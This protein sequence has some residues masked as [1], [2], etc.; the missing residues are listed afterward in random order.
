VSV[1]AVIPVWNGRELLM[2]LLDT[3]EAQTVKFAEV[4]ILDNGSTDGGPE[5]AANRGA[6]VVRLGRNQGFAAAVNRGVAEAQTAKVAILNTDVELGPEWLDRLLLS[7]A[8]F[9]TGRIVSAADPSVIDGT[10]DLLCRGG[11]PWRAG[12]GKR[13]W[14]PGGPIEIAPFTAVL[15]DRDA[16]LEVGMLDEQF[17]S[18]LEDV[19]F[20]LRCADLGIRGEFIPEAVCRHHGSATLGRWNADSV[21]RMSRNQVFLIAKH[22]P[23]R[24]IL[25]AGWAILVAQLLWGLVAARHGAGWGW[26][27]GKIEGI[28]RF[29]EVR[30]EPIEDLGDLLSRQEAAIQELQERLGMDCYWRTYFFWGGAK[31]HS[32]TRGVAT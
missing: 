19:D 25:E 11:C 18:Y 7:K 2:K 24:L 21:R 1:T 4:L 28:A 22:Y 12:S 14:I 5:A 27:R 23:G 16:F 10:F 15:F 26:L 8:R 31:R 13:G 32:A 9:A 17:E 30:G 29:R 20:G 6:Q 3:I